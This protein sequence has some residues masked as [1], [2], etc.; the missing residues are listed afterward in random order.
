MSPKLSVVIPCYNEEKRIPVYFDSY[1]ER[2]AQT[3]L[4]YEFVLVDDGSKDRTYDML[5][6]RTQKNSRIRV[7]THHPN[8]GRGAGVREGVL[9]AKGEFIFETDIDGSYDVPEMLKFL[10]YLEEHPE[11]DVVIATREHRDAKAVINQTALRIFAGKVFHAIFHI[12]FGDEFSDV[13]AGCKMYRQ[14]PAQVIFRHQYDNEFLG[15]AE[16]VYAAVKLGYKVKELPVT[17]TDDPAGSKVSPF[18]AARRT[19]AGLLK[20]KMRDF[21]GK[22][23]R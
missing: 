6:D 9:A 17:W 21:K 3:G 12:F 13:M 22:Y 19:L 23:R 4:D 14:A 10:A 7:L 1:A 16:T 18:R 20:M 5:L 8:M 15:A 11:I 2:V